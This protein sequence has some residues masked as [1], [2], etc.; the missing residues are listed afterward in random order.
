[1]QSKPIGIQ[2]DLND[3]KAGKIAKY[4]KLV[5]GKKGLWA[6]FKYEFIIMLCS[7]MPGALGLFLRTK[8]Y[9][10][11]L[12][13]VGRNVI[14]G[15]NVTLRHPYKIKIGDNV[16]ID[17]NCLLDAKGGET[18]GI[19]IDDGVFIGRNTIISCKDGTIKIGENS[20][21][22]FNCEVFS[23]SRV[24]LG[25]NS[26]F[27]AYCYVV[28]GQHKFDR[29]DVS[30]LEQ[31][32]QSKGIIIEDNVWFGAGVKVMDG[33]RIGRDTVVGASALV[34]D[35]LPEYSVCVGIPAKVV[36]IRKSS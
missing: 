18:S 17:D 33:V 4:Q 29:T 25:K 32:R 19:T 34:R 7:V 3:P 14:F 6:L 26:L 20:N 21:I 15:T 10:K 8:L 30:V 35:N 5:I 9:P 2:Q 16:V 36:K 1:M 27:A 23:A 13:S 11:L 31:D 28:G 12:G 22:G 24:V